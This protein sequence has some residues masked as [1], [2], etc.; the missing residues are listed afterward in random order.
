MHLSCAHG[1]K[2]PSKINPLQSKNYVL[3]YLARHLATF[4]TILSKS[5]VMQHMSS[6]D[7]DA[8]NLA[9]RPQILIFLVKL[10]QWFRGYVVAVKTKGLC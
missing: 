1:R 8:E 10:H 3:Y 2:P 6:E 7:L 4:L 5:L 9:F